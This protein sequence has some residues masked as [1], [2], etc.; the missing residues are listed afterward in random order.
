MKVT[1][2]S[3]FF[4]PVVTFLFLFNCSLFAEPVSRQSIPIASVEVGI[5]K[6]P[7]V[8]PNTLE[9]RRNE[10]ETYLE[11]AQ[12]RLYDFAKKYGYQDFL[13]TSII[14]RVEIFD[15]KE[16]F[17][18]RMIQLDGMPAGTK[19]PKTFMGVGE[20][21]VLYCV[22]PEIYRDN[23]PQ[24]IEPDSYEKFLCHEMA[25]VLHVRILQGKD[26]AM[27][28]V[29]FYEGFAIFAADQLKNS[30]PINDEELWTIVGN[31]E[32]GSYLKYAFLIRRFVAL[33]PISTL[34]SRASKPAFIG[35]LHL[36]IDQ[37]ARKS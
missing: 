25:H 10:L 27:G 8:I 19:I 17:D 30:A 3:V 18:K 33:A 4:L 6:V 31:P 23:F 37:E 2:Y 21:G 20:K 16:E 12:R 14:K 13:K 9:K 35:F 34:V 1:A 28:P 29:W 7:I 5:F 11:K 15:M 36:L 26:E 22:I 32:R 24:G